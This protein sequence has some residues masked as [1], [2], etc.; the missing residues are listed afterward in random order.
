[1]LNVRLHGKTSVNWSIKEM[2]S[3]VS[4]AYVNSERIESTRG[5]KPDSLHIATGSLLYAALRV[6]RSQTSWNTF[7]QK[8]K[9]SPY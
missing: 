7:K 4:Y 5:R 2:I 3:Q 9:Q 6:T 1:M 8:T